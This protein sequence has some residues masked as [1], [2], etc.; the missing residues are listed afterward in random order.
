MHNIIL[1]IFL[2]VED[3]NLSKALDACIQTE[4]PLKDWNEVIG[5][6]EAKKALMEAVEYP[7]KYPWLFQNKINPPKGVLLYGPPGV[8]KTHL[9]LIAASMSGAA[10][11]T[12]RGSDIKSKWLG[13][14]E[15]FVK[16]MFQR[17]KQLKKA[18]IFIDEVDSIL[19]SRDGQSND[20]MDG[21][22]NEFLVELNENQ[23]PGVWFVLIGA[24]NY[25]E[26]I[27]VAMRSRF[28]HSIRLQMPTDSEKAKMYNMFLSN[29][30][31]QFQQTDYFH[32]AS[33]SKG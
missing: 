24:T 19:K 6:D 13:D 8:A 9:A 4:L 16:A 27:D 22:V 26:K 5:Q 31:Y 23:L 15:R 29:C 18:V 11:V 1:I 28:Q 25:P 20:S 12:L 14:S 3:T 32:F 10:L 30:G 17:I 7:L 21:T 33:Q 2:Y